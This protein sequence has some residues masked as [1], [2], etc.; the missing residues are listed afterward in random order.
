[1]ERH[2]REKYFLMEVMKYFSQATRKIFT[3]IF[4]PKL[5][6]NLIPSLVFDL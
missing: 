3:N 4:V 5:V 1:M 2:Q 6:Q